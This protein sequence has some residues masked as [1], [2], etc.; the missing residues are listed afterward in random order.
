M[1]GP[2]LAAADPPIWPDVLGVDVGGTMAKA[3]VL[4]GDGAVRPLPSLATPRELGPQAVVSTIL[5]QVEGFVGLSGAVRAVSAVG[6]VVPGVVDDRSGVAEYSENL[7]W[8]DI[9][10][11]DLVGDR[12]GLPVGFGHDVR[13]GGLAERLSGAAQ[14]QGDVVFVAIGTGISGA[15]TVQ[16]LTLDGKL[17]G[18]IGHLDVGTGLPCLCGGRGCLE[19]VAAGPAIAAAWSARTGRPADGARVVFAAAAGGDREAGAVIDDAVDALARA[20]AAY[21]TLLAPT[22]VVLGGGVAL[23]GDQLLVPLRERL[24]RALPWQQ[25]PRVVPSALG[26]LAGAI[27]AAHLARRAWEG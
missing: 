15:V 20:L 24:A 21:V 23:A 1:A 16:G 7:G 9:P 27:G 10:F 3:V 25:V 5:D 2:E 6:L 22:V 4:T 12:T 14:G 19:T 17:V 13:A 18:E 8:R 26:D 11:R